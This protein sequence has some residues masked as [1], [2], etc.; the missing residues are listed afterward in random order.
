MLSDRNIRYIITTV[1]LFGVIWIWLGPKM[2]MMFTGDIE[3]VGWASFFMI[4]TTV[5]FLFVGILAFIWPNRLSTV[6]FFIFF[7]VH[8]LVGVGVFPK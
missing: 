3:V 5:L 2:L 7:T 4:H 1:S 8:L 6:L